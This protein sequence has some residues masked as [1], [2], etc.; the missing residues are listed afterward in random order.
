[1]DQSGSHRRGTHGR[2]RDGV[3]LLL[4]SRDKDDAAAALV[5]DDGTVWLFNSLN[6]TLS[7]IPCSSLFYSDASLTLP[8]KRN[9]WH[10]L[11]YL[12]QIRIGLPSLLYSL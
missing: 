11:A 10:V 1:M 12:L 3:Q 8:G 5:V 4:F 6:D 2:N 7:E 9:E